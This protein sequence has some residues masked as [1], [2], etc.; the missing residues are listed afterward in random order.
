MTTAAQPMFGASPP[1]ELWNAIDWRTTGRRVLR[2]QTRIA[3]AT[4]E[5]ELPGPYSGPLQ[6]LSRMRG[7]SHV[8]FL[9]EDEPAMVHPYPTDSPKLPAFPGDDLCVECQIATEVVRKLGTS[10]A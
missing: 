10:A 1:E 5:V 4:R 7:N 9:G 8:R 6:G 3:K 2:L